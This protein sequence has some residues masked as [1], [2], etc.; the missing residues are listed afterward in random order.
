MDSETGS[1][2]DVLA[3][4]W[5]SRLGDEFSKP[6]MDHLRQ[7]LQSEYRKGA[8]VFPEKD[9]IFRALQLVDFND[10]KVVILGQDPYHGEHQ[11]IGMAFAVQSPTSAPPSLK[12]IFKEIQSDLSIPQPRN[13][14]LTGWAEQ[15]VLLLNTVLTVRA[16]EAF[17]HRNQGW[18]SF[19]DRVIS[20]L[21]MHERP[22]VF[23]LWGAPS[24]QKAKM[25]TNPQHFIL[26]APHPSPLSAHRGFFGCHHFSKTNAFLKERNVEPINWSKS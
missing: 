19:T 2:Q 20:E 21:N 9:K 1:G 17:S 4:G 11:A 10:V 12:N 8:K 14:E 16:N 7:F 22:L 18:E 13:T 26:R 23:L 6:Y 24:Q 15:G 3:P 25:I 5:A